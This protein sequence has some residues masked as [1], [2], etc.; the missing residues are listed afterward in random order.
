MEATRTWTEDVPLIAKDRRCQP[1]R[2]MEWRGGRRDT[3]WTNRPPGSLEQ[4]AARQAVNRWR[5][6]RL[7]LRSL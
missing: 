2:R 1:D 4:F 3:D 6:L 5:W 7:P